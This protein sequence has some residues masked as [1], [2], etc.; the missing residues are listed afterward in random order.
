[1][2]DPERVMRVK[3]LP[4]IVTN[5]LRVDESPV[6]TEPPVPPE[7][8]MPPLPA[9]VEPEGPVLELFETAVPPFAPEPPLEP[10]DELFPVSAAT[11]TLLFA[12]VW[13]LLLTLTSLLS[14]PVL[15]KWSVVSSW[16]ELLLN[17]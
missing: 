8:P 3:V 1:M 14:L 17:V 13:A 6:L 12:D 9:V 10:V 5:W 16:P 4:E 7:P 15:V 11:F 2:V